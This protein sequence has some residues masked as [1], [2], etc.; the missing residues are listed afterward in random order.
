MISVHSYFSLSN[1]STLGYSSASSECKM[2]LP[3]LQRRWDTACK[4]AACRLLL[5][6]SAALLLYVTPLFADDGATLNVC[7]PQ[8]TASNALLHQLATSL[9]SHKRDKTSHTKVQ[10]LE[11]EGLDEILYT[12]NPYKGNF[13]KQSLSTGARDRA[14]KEQC[15]Y[16]LVIAL[17]DV[18]TARSA[19]PNAWSPEPQATT[20]T[21]DPYMRNQDPDIYVQ[22]KYRL[23]RL[24]A[25]ES[26]ID[27]FVTTHA[28]APQ[29]AVVAQ[30]LDMLA[31]QVFSKVTK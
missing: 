4:V 21:G 6:L 3:K 20:N 11:L 19:Q 1:Y 18:K 31:N 30:A 13:A 9:S 7:I 10:G 23:Y 22:V 17:P 28:A 16:L 25:N 2:H 29:Q 24:G 8:H 12:D 27:G 14:L 5:L 15:S 26:F